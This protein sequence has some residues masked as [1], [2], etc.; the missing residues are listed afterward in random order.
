VIHAIERTQEVSLLSLGIQGLKE[1]DESGEIL[2]K[3]IRE[4]GRR[5]F[6]STT[7]TQIWVSTVPR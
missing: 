7:S 3:S 6:C 1:E 2:G 5:Y 4:P